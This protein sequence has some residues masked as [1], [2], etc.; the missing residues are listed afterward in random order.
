M[1]ML[2]LAGRAPPAFLV[3]FDPA[4]NETAALKAALSCVNVGTDYFDLFAFAAAS[5]QPKDTIANHKK[6][7]AG[8]GDWTGCTVIRRWWRRMHWRKN[9]RRDRQESL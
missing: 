5:D 3:A 4:E 1:L 2:T 7:K 6:W 8:A 9:R